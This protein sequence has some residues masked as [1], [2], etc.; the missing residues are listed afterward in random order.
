MGS[1]SVIYR[2]D[3]SDYIGVKTIQGDS[4]SLD[5]VEPEMLFRK[6]NE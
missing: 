6:L 1:F 4:T 3:I 2:S 5:Q